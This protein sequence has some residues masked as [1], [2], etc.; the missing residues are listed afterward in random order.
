MSVTQK[1]EIIEKL[2]SAVE[3]LHGLGFYHGDL[4]PEN[5]I[6]KVNDQDEARI[7]LLDM[8]DFTPSQKSNLNYSYAPPTAENA[9]EKERDNFAVMRIA[10]EILG[11]RWGEHSED[12]PELS[13]VFIN[14]LADNKFGFMKLDRFKAALQPKSH[15]DWIDVVIK[16]ARE[17]D[18]LI[19]PDNDE[20]YISF[21]TNPKNSQELTVA[22]CG[23]GGILEFSYDI[24]K[25]D[26]FNLIFK[27]REEISNRIKDQS[28]TTI[29]IGIKLSFKQSRSD[30]CGLTSLFST[31]G[32]LYNELLTFVESLKVAKDEKDKDSSIDASPQDSN[33]K[34]FRPSTH[35]LWEKI[36]KT[37]M[38]SLP[39]ITPIKF[40]KK[41]GFHYLS[42]ECSSDEHALDGIDSQDIVDLIAKNP[43]TDNDLF[44]G[45]IDIQ[46][47]TL[48]MLRLKQEPK[49][50][51]VVDQ[52][53]PLFLQSR[54]N[55]ASFN[56]RKHALARILNNESIIENLPDYFDDGNSFLGNKYAVEIKDDDFKRYD[57]NGLSLNEAQRS[58]FKKIINNGPISLLQGPPGTGKTEFIA[59]FT[60][61]LF[62]KQSVRNILLVSQSHEAVNTAADRIRR[63]CQRL[64]TPLQV[65]RFSNRESAVSPELQDTFSQNVISAKREALKASQFKRVTDFAELIGLP[66]EYISRR[67]ELELE[68]GEDIERHQRLTQERPS[69]TLSDSKEYDRIC[70][71]IE[72]NIKNSFSKLFNITNIPNNNFRGSLDDLIKRLDLDFAISIK[73]S[74]QAKNLISL[75]REMLMALSN[76]RVS[77]DEFLAR[78]RQLVVGTC[79]GIGQ[80]HIG[81]GET[82]YDWVIIDEAARSVSSELAIAMQ[83]GKRILLVGDHKQL[84]P[85]YQDEHKM[86]LARSLNIPSR[87]KELDYI[88]G[89]DFERIFE[90]AYGKKVSASLDTQYRMAPAIGTLV[91]E[92]FYNGKLVNGKLEKQISDIY[93]ALPKHFQSTVTWLSTDNL[94][95]AQHEKRNGSLVNHAE[96]DIIISLLKDLEC[97]NSFLESDIAYNCITKGEAAIGIIC[98][99]AE[100]KQLIRKKFNERPWANDFKELVK[101][102]TVDSYQGKENHIV[103]TSL[104]RFD[105]SKTPGFLRLPNRINVALS[106]AMDKLIIVG[107]T[108][109]WMDRGSHHPL[110]QVL[111]MI[112]DKSKNDHSYSVLAA[113]NLN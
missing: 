95:N 111:S 79:V 102:D 25:K 40:T 93:C 46:H 44:V 63:H 65:V 109:T 13:E 83:S 12:F 67:L 38:E 94:P 80:S 37:E 101:I 5:I 9:S 14:E 33:L 41:D 89:S 58:A 106:R 45:S 21:Q 68:L 18:F 20:L 84:P 66:Y 56:R 104:T 100:Q 59:A 99:Y 19:Y 28:I 51:W 108:S 24:Y 22:F 52:A 31:D 49:N 76:E 23:I 98:M 85:L 15:I 43:K 36:L 77:Y 29:P 10:S 97:N 113:E 60:H 3:H 75:S 87:G 32:L 105:S 8:L 70:Q 2:T 30:V 16:S 61:F 26:F 88:I 73:Q 7:I 57:R 34:K 47:S 112:L 103:I 27:K 42:Y 110:G 72:S 91:S 62:E 6:F 107:A 54:E 11:I 78:S 86:A 17:A 74:K 39:S 71:G 90:S 35:L 55:K 48:N 82:T 4:H 53:L 96:A 64:N 1:F 69:I 50:Q 81:V 92:C